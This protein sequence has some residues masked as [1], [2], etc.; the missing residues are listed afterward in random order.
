MPQLREHLH[1]RSPVQTFSGSGVQPL[2]DG[3]ELALRVAGQVRALGQILAQQAIRIFISPALPRA[4][5]IGKEHLDGQPLSQALVVGHLLA[6]I[7]GQ[8]FP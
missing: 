1:G 5:R 4:M 8:G 2:R 3:I 6:P 7:I